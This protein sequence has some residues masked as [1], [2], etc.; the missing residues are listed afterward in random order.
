MRVRNRIFAGLACGLTLGAA[1]AQAGSGRFSRDTGLLKGHSALSREIAGRIMGP[2]GQHFAFDIYIN[3]DCG[4][5]ELLGTWKLENGVTSKR[6]NPHPGAVAINIYNAIFA[7]FSQ[8]LFRLCSAESKGKVSNEY[9]VSAIFAS[10]WAELCRWPEPRAQK[11]ENLAALYHFIMGY[12][13]PPE[14]YDSWSKW[15]FDQFQNSQ[16]KEA[17]PQMVHALLFNPYFLLE[18]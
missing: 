11:P 6:V 3:G 10:T 5:S 16:A 4:L 12:E 8:E 7:A 13:A 9:A 1:L 17:L 15:V 14:E 18:N 2:A